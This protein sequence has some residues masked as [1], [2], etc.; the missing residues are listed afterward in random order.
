MKSREEEKTQGKK[1][2][3]IKKKR[4]D[5]QQAKE[6]SVRAAMIR[7]SRLLTVEGRTKQSRQGIKSDLQRK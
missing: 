7:G 5:P 1:E 4:A 2:A 6:R 3:I